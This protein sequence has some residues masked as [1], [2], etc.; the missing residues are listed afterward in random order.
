[1]NLG[2]PYLGARN[3]QVDVKNEG[4]VPFPAAGIAGYAASSNLLKGDVTAFNFIAR[5]WV[6]L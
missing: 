3:F 6:M 2:R 1:L 5:M 4:A